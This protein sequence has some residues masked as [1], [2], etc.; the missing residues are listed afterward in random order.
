MFHLSNSLAIGSLF[1]VLVFSV[2]CCDTA[3]T[4]AGCIRVEHPYVM[5]GGGGRGRAVAAAGGRWRPRAAAPCRV[6]LM[7]HGT[8]VLDAKQTRPS[9]SSPVLERARLRETRAN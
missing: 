5:S 8:Q 6:A 4:V 1:V 3:G 7:G 9:L 2:G